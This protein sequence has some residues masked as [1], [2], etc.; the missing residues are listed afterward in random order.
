M[1]K[2]CPAHRRGW[3][4]LISTKLYKDFGITAVFYCVEFGCGEFEFTQVN[5]NLHAHETTDTLW[6]VVRNNTILTQIL[7]Q[8]EKR[9]IL[10]K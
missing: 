4:R 2:Q 9:R 3:H 6:S 10:R 7:L 8:K 1:A 5:A